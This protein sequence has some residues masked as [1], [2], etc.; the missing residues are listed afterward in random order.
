M[1]LGLLPDG[2][3]EVLCVVNHPTKGVLNWEL[4][5]CNGLFVGHYQWS[6]I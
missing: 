1:M 2:T 3:R 6:I 4:D 5:L